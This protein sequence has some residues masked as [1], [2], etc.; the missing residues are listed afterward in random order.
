M[1]KII[2]RNIINNHLTLYFLVDPLLWWLVVVVEGEEVDEGVLFDFERVL[3]LLG[4]LFLRGLEEEWRPLFFGCLSSSSDPW[5][6]KQQHKPIIAKI[7]TRIRTTPPI[8]RY[9][10]DFD[11]KK[12]GFSGIPPRANWGERENILKFRKSCSLGLPWKSCP[13]T[14]LPMPSKGDKVVVVGIVGR[15]YPSTYSS[16]T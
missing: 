13:P 12:L 16:A 14:N 1:Q 8:T 7:I 11:L 3:F 15:W 9:W 10:K 2:W 4:L 5:P 6:Q